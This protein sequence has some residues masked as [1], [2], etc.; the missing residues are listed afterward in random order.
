MMSAVVLVILTVLVWPSSNPTQ[1]STSP[2]RG[3]N[4][5]AA[6]IANPVASTAESTATGRRTYA[7]LCAGCHGP[8]GKGDGGQAVGGGQPADLTDDM[9][10]FGSTDG[11]IFTVIRD[12]TSVD[13]EAYAERL[14]ETQM[15]DVVN[16]IRTLRSGNLRNQTPSPGGGGHASQTEEK[17]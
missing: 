16:F 5:E 3:G 8:Q 12:G 10:D 13:M 1:A 11:E 2:R 7:R 15:W 6:R 17:S 4:P 9:W 14:T